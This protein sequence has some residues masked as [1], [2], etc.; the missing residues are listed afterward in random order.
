MIPLAKQYLTAEMRT[1]IVDVLNSGW[2]TMGKVTEQLEEEF[3]K[4]I[5][6]KY[7]IAVNS[8]SMA[9]FF[10]VKALCEG[11]SFRAVAT[12][13]LTFA[14]T[15]NSILLNDGLFPV[16][17]DVNKHTMCI[18]V[19]KIFLE[20]RSIYLSG[21]ILVN[22]GGQPCDM[23]KVEV[24]KKMDD[25]FWIVQ[26]CAH[27]VETKWNN[28]I[29]GS[30]GDIACYSFNPTKNI[31]APEMGMVTTDSEDIA[32]KIR[33]WRIHGM[34]AESSKRVMAPGS[35][36][37]VDLGYKANSTDIEAIVAL[38]SLKRVEEN[39]KIR[40]DIAT[41]YCDAFLDFSEE[42]LFNGSI[43]N[44]IYDNNGL[45]HG[46]HLFIILINNRDNFIMKMRDS[47]IFCGIHYKPLHL[48]PYYAKLYN[49][50]RGD[51]PNAEY[52]GD[53]CV[54]LP[55][56]PGMSNKDVDFVIENIRDV[57]KGK[58]YLF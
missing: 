3:A 47:G 1:G 18:D 42:G 5:G 56:G 26:D 28:K 36:S 27:A 49:F 53:H 52:I 54:S 11:R 30:Y 22:F 38:E 31:A 40:E 37:I 46:L 32:K 12:T 21:M 24:L 33:R 48:H 44:T 39:W 20:C 58:K 45:K 15:I 17:F 9:L 23:D 4:Y 35:Y 13:P 16:L 41:K 19:E 8:C 55:L 50:S 57:L 7:A 10:S 14:S 25:K 51:F 2:W 43:P 34:D 6:V 29:I